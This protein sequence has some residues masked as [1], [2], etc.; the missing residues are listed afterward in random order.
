MASSVAASRQSQ[1]FS[2]EK[3]RGG[4]HLQSSS[5]LVAI[6]PGRRSLTRSALGY[7]RSPRWGFGAWGRTVRGC[8]GGCPSRKVPEVP[9]ACGRNVPGA[10]ELPA[11]FARGTRAPTPPVA[12]LWIAR[13]G[14]GC[15]H[16]VSLAGRRDNRRLDSGGGAVEL[17]RGGQRGGK[18]ADR[19]LDAPDRGVGVLAGRITL[20]NDVIIELGFGQA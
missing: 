17:D 19:P 1:A 3:S 2:R 12:P 9:Y 13:A 4:P 7:Y 20:D 18:A 8:G 16:R 10:G 6:D 5:S 14:G 11:H 15:A